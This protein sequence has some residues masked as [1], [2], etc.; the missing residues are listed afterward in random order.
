MAR[1]SAEIKNAAKRQEVWE[2]E[3][4]EKA[5]SKREKKRKRQKEL[6][7]DEEIGDQPTKEPRTLETTRET[8]VTVVTRDDLQDVE[9]DE[10]DD[11]FADP[12]TPKVMITTRPRP[13]KDLFIFISNL[14]TLMPHA[15]PKSSI[16]RPSVSCVLSKL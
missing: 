9:G 7:R 11:E 2:R 13:S 1:R 8:E 5:L 10:N 16:F 3:K 12:R 15:V 6:A 4:A 14:M